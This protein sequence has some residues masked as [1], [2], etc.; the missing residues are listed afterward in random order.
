M[1]GKVREEPGKPVTVAQAKINY[2]ELVK[3]DPQ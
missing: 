2:L 1:D 3:Q